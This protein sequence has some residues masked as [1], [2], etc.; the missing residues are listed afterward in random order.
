MAT[1]TLTIPD[2]LLPGL[3]AEFHLLTIAGNSDYATPEAYLQA[4]AVELIRQR[5]QQYR[6]GPY[7]VPAAP[8]VFNADGT[9]YGVPP[10]PTELGQEW[11]HPETGKLWRVVQ[12]QGQDGQFLPDDPTTP[13]RESLEWVEVQP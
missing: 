10:A 7:W 12:R 4:S 13:Q 11:T 5:C 8:P 2:E 9:P 6:V 3:A 1:F